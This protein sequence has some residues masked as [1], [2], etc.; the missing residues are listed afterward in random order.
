MGSYKRAFSRVAMLID[1]IRGLITPLI[2]SGE[3][4]SIWEFPKIRGTLFWGP[5]YKDS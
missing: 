2:T 4:L 3:P 5:Y 1:H